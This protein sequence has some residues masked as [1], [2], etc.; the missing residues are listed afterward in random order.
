MEEQDQQQTVS[1]LKPDELL[2]HYTDQN[3]LLGIIGDQAFRATDIR[4]L[5]DTEEF[6]HGLRTAIHM[7]EQAAANTGENGQKILRYLKANLR[8]SF[9]R[10][11]VY[12]VS[13][14]GPLKKHELLPDTMDDPGDRLNMWRSYSGPGIGYSIG[15][16][17]D[18]IS[19]KNVT[20]YQI[21]INGVDRQECSYRQ[22]TKEDYLTD[23]LKRTQCRI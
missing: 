6:E 17:T 16:P 12:S 5:N 14:T 20:E 19:P 7:A 22:Q 11:P 1:L 4:F 9:S 13:L 18:P 3:G 8:F 2:Y 15:I 10:Q 23:I 21:D